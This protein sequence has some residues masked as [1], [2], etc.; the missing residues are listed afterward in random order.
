MLTKAQNNEVILLLD[1]DMLL[2]QPLTTDF[3]DSSVKFWKPFHKDTLER[4][5]KVAPGVMFGQTY[6]LG[7]KWVDFKSLAGPNSPAHEVD[8]RDAQLFYQ[9]GP[10]YIGV[11][12]DMFKVVNRWAELVREVHKEKPQLLSEMYAYQLAAADQKLPHELVT[13]MMISAVDTYG[14]AWDYIDALPNEEVC[15]MGASPNPSKY[16]LPTLLHYCQHYGVANVLFA[17]R[18]IPHNIFTC[19]SPLLE[20]PSTDAM[21]SHN[22]YNIVSRGKRQERQNLGGKHH[23]RHVF[24]SCAITSAVNEA[25]LFFKH[26]HCDKTANTEKTLSLT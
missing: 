3:S 26:H 16:A 5:K 2:L 11:V 4:K 21:S 25:A 6:G 22:A 10:P 20:E 13:S 15:R 18:S 1:P 12:S 19:Q 23:K 17:K 24:S 8:K 9:P 14:E 7:V